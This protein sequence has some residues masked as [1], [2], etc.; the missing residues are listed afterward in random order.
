MTYRERYQKEC[1]DT[2]IYFA[3]PADHIQL[4]C[5]PNHVFKDVNYEE[6][7]ALCRAVKSDCD[8]CWDTEAAEHGDC[9]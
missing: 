6:K 3:I 1:V 9:N 5:C 8:K 2:H 7:N 4:H